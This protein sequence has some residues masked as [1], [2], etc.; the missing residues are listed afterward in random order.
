M[1][2]NLQQ[3]S[4][5]YHLWTK[6]GWSLL[7]QNNRKMQTDDVTQHLL[8]ELETKSGQIY[9]ISS[10]IILLLNW[11]TNAFPTFQSLPSSEG[12][13]VISSWMKT[14]G[15]QGEKWWLLH[16]L[17]RILMLC[18]WHSMEW[19]SKTY[20]PHEGPEQRDW[21]CSCPVWQRPSSV[22][23]ISCFPPMVG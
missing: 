22:P 11:I 4:T 15:T 8:T 13:P 7:K 17:H 16:L 21:G 14:G 12:M 10:H 5:K 18:H 3:G 6:T 19:P 2:R 1:L 9:Q 23:G 20:C